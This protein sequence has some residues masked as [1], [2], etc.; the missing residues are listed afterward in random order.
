MFSADKFQE[1]L[2]IVV[3]QFPLA[4]WETVYVTLIATLFA[5]V[6]GLP[7][8]VLLVT[9]KRMVSDRCQTG[10]TDLLTCLSTF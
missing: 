8:G 4:L 2:E 6:I 9:G 3:S 10:L 7:L 5:T 1:A